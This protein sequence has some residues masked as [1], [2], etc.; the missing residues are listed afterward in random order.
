MKKD[1]INKNISL[2]IAKFKKY[3]GF[4]LIEL[5]ISLITISCIAAAFAPVIT[6]R[7]SSQSNSVRSGTQVMGDCTGVSGITN[8]D[9]CSLC[10]P[11]ECVVCNLQC[12]FNQAL[13]VKKCECDDCSSVTDNCET[14]KYTDDNA[15]KP[16]V[17]ISCL[18]GYY[19]ENKNCN[20]NC[21][22]RACPS[23]KCCYDGISQVECAKEYT[24][25]SN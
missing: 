16:Q 15:T 20:N 13:N 5:M 22:C 12:G 10:Y 6:K 14:C 8:G 1:K 17:C 9:K 19:L 21:V 2:V 18:K 7:L 3:L 4:S 11:G 23:D 24:Q 25:T